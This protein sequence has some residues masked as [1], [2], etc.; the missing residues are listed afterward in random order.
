MK[1]GRGFKRMNINVDAKLHDAFKAI[2]A[3]QGKKMTDILLRFIQEYVKKN[4]SA[5]VPTKGGR[6]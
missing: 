5:A 1:P 3:A 4:Q 2:T 6:S